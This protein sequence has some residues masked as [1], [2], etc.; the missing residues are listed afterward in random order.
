[1]SDRMQKFLYRVG[2]LLSF[3]LL[4]SSPLFAQDTV[5]F[6]LTGV[7]Q[8]VGISST[9][10]Q[11]GGVYTSPYYGD[12]ETDDSPGPTVPVICDDFADNSFIP[13][14][15]TAYVTPLS[16]ILSETTTD[17]TLKFS[18][19]WNGTTGPA[20]SPSLTLTQTQTYTAAAILA[21]DI[22]NSTGLAQD[23]YSYALWELTDPQ[24]A[25]SALPG[26]DQAAVQSYLQTAVTEAESNNPSS[27][28]NGD[29][30]TFYSY[31]APPNGMIPT[32]G[33]SPCA[34]LPPQEFIT[35][36]TPEPSS[37]ALLGLDFL[38]LSGLVLFARRRLAKSIIR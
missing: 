25:S 18:T 32:C 35:V 34:S 16:S 10:P 23:E 19:G 31:D 29:T 13:E 15:W 21:V 3:V 38:G 17:S 24:A 9:A 26:G 8:D 28:L 14:S 36:S 12:I 37:P 22:L 6:N 7:G 4:V 20:S 30:V 27:Y 5:T 2:G 11:L 1:M 33:G